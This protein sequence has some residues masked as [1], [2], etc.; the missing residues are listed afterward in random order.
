MKNNTINRGVIKK[1]ALALGELNSSV[2]YVGG[3]TVGLYINDPAADDV[4]PTMD[5]DISLSLVS[6]TELENI[7]NNLI[8][9]GFKQSHED[10]VIC[11]FRY[12]DVIVDFMNTTPLGWAPG[13]RWF[14]SGFLNKELIKIEDQNIFVLPLPYFIA[15]KIDAYYDRG[16]NEPRMSSDFEDIIYIIDNNTNFVNE[17]MSAE[18]DVQYF[19]QNELK[20]FLED[21]SKQEAVLGNLFYQ[22]REE[23]YKLFIDKIKAITASNTL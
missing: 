18:K 19:I 5:I 4:R 3:A 6:L 15:S 1:I 7:R 16:A 23:R 9:K 11:R 21:K 17:I 14:G 2:V 12:E 22:T 20:T 13:N 8:N 10:N